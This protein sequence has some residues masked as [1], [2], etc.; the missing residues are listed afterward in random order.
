MNGLEQIAALAILKNSTI[1]FIREIS[2]LCMDWITNSNFILYLIWYFRRQD[3][4]LKNIMKNKI[5][6][7]RAAALWNM[8]NIRLKQKQKY[9]SKCIFPLSIRD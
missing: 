2:H 1:Y 5:A 7:N 3:I 6:K 4:K 9:V 8:R